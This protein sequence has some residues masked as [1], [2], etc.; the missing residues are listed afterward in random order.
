MGGGGVSTSTQ[1]TTDQNQ[2]AAQ[3]FAGMR[4]GDNNLGAAS[5]SAGSGG[6]FL[7]GLS[8]IMLGLLAVAALAGLW[9]WKH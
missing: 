2:R 3:G 1:Q 4:F 5:G 7:S 9:I 6:G 8:P